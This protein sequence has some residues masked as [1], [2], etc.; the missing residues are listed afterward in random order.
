MNNKRNKTRKGVALLVVLLIVMAITI[1]SLGFVTKT[2]VELSCGENMV[3]RT[4]MDHLAESAIAHARGLIL[5]P[6]DTSAEYWTGANGIQLAAGDDYYNVSIARDDSVATNRCNYAVKCAAYRL[7]GGS[8]IGRSNL[9]AELRLDPAV[10]LWTGASSTLWSGVTIN[11]D[12]FCNGAL[13]NSGT[14]NGDVFA[15]SLSGGATGQQSAVAELALDWPSLDEGDFSG[16]YYIGSSA[17]VAQSI[18]PGTYDEVSWGP[19][20]GNPAGVYHCNG[21]L[22]L[23]DRVLINGMLVV[24]GNLTINN[25]RNVITA[26]KNFPALLVDG[27]LEVQDDN[28]TLE[29]NGLAVVNGSMN[30]N[31]DTNGVTVSGGL[32]VQGSIARTTK[33]SSVNSNNGIPYNNP[34][35][36][37]GGGR[38]DH[39]PDFDGVDDYILVANSSSLQLTNQLTISAW[40]KGDSW[41]SGSSVD[42][43]VRKGP[44]NPN[45]Y[46]FAIAD[47]RVA[48]MLDDSDT[49]GH[50]GDTVLN[51]GQ[52]YH[53]AAT[54]G[55]SV[56]KIYVD[57]EP[58]ASPANDGGNIG[59]DTR[60]LY[61]GGRPGGDSFNG[62]IDDIQI[63]N[64]TLN[65]DDIDDIKNG[66]TKSGLVAHW[67]LDEQN[68]GGNV[69]VTTYPDKAA[70]QVWPTSGNQTRWTPAAGAFFKSISRL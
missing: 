52:W 2:D 43:I 7:D 6:Q 28:G 50:R 35:W 59:T 54:W 4:E 20:A 61:L 11:G 48:L 9:S 39:S 63:Y 31:L 51:P 53:V 32:F 55:G 70:I 29:V 58:D 40:V 16:V 67:K 46:Q 23:E 30:V 45:N 24:D 1:A 60:P 15:D 3:L 62:R 34:I 27:K 65:Q 8:T 13:T 66:S 18:A 57:Q 68:N 36:G 17:Y 37:S 42:V 21:N 56:V 41:S 25:E 10:A 19:S 12:V 5:N 49:G 64:W 26:V 69:T 22:T 33:D 38:I 44:F 47:G 14:I